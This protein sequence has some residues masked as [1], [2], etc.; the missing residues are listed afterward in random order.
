MG[1]A[2]WAI[3]LGFVVGAYGTLIGA[4]GGF[5]LMPVLLMLYP[6]ESPE[7]LTSISLAVVFFNAASGSWAYAR[8][9]RIDYR[10]G[11][12][13]SAATVPGAIFGAL[14]TG[15]LPRRLFDGV[16][17]VILGAQVGARWSGR[18]QGSWILRGLALAL[19][20]VGV[21]IVFMAL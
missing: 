1:D 10:S 4:G 15:Y 7:L 13:F 18:I 20:L 9:R 21:R 12:L 6:R 11:L 5:V 14:T 2:L 17:G 19:G 3:P 16:F 8:L